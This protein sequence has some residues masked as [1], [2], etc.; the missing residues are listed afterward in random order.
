[1]HVFPQTNNS[2]VA[3]RF[4]IPD[5]H[6]ALDYVRPDFL[7]QRMLGRS[8]IM[9]DAIQ[10][11]QVRPDAPLSPTASWTLNPVNNSK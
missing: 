7:M 2:A 1:M 6:F 10:P 5:T 11:T 3:A 4:T 8:L 9:W